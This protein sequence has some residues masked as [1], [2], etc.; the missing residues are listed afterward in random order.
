VGDEILGKNTG[1]ITL[2]DG[3]GPAATCFEQPTQPLPEVCRIT[4]RLGGIYMTVA[5]SHTTFP[6]P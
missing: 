4:S 5:I 2:I 1:K 6:I 3:V